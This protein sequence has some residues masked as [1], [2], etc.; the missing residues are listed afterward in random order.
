MAEHATYLWHPLSGYEP[1]R[2]VPVLQVEEELRALLIAS[3]AG[4]AADYRRFLGRLGSH[5]RAYYKGKLARS[6]RSDTEAEDLVQETLM[7]IHVRRHTYD[8]TQPVT[9]WIHAIA[10]Y[11]LIDHFRRTRTAA[12]DVPVEDA[13]VL[14]ALDDHVAAESSLDVERLLAHLPPKM[15]NAI[16]STKVEGLSAAE[17]A[18]RAGM[19]E[20]AIKVSV[21]RGLKTLANLVGGKAR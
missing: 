3:L 4:S 5:L 19:S 21:H 8:V 10:R 14:V 9:P 17:A 18:D 20:T 2:L 15:R 6:G 16:L 1:A 13:G 11:K 12:A 7:V